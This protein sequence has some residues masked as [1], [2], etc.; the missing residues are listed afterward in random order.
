M[1]NSFLIS[2]FMSF[3]W[4]ILRELIILSSSLTWHHGNSVLEYNDTVLSGFTGLLVHD[5]ESCELHKIKFYI[6]CKN[7]YIFIVFRS[8][9]QLIK[10]LCVIC[11]RITCRRKTDNHRPY[12]EAPR[13]SGFSALKCSLTNKTDFYVYSWTNWL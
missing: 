1:R 13:N 5:Y 12:A 8:F 10:L 11:N 9:F 6:S 7:H 4:I 3:L 2:Y